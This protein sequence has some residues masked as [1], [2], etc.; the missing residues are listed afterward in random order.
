MVMVQECPRDT[1][2]VLVGSR[3][4]RDRHIP[5]G[6]VWKIDSQIP[7]PLSAGCSTS[8]RLSMSLPSLRH[9]DGDG[10]VDGDDDGDDGDTA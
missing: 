7:T 4:P 9:P 1:P 6:K 10:D 5:H 8:Q 3:P 2:S